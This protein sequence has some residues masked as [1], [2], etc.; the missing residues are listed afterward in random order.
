MKPRAKKLFTFSTAAAL[1]L[2]S[3]Q[4]SALAATDTTYDTSDATSFVFSDSG[5]TVTEGSYTGYKTS[6]TDL[7]INK[8][9]TYV[10]SGDC[11]DG[12]ITVKKGTTGVILVMDG[13]TLTSDDTAPI[14]CNKSTGVTI[15]AADDSTNT[16]TDSAE[17][18]D[19]NY[20]DNEN[21]ENAV[22]K[23]KDGSQVTICGNGT[24]NINANGKNGIKSGSTTDDEGEAWLQIEDATLNITSE[25]G[26]A[27]NAE[28]LLTIASGTITADADDDGIHCDYTLNIGSTGSEGPAINIKNCYEGLEAATL[29]IYSGDIDIHAEDDCLNGANSDLTDYD[30]SITIAGGDLDMDTT[31]GD[32]IDSNGTLT[33]TGGNTEVWTA[34]TSDNQPLD[35]DDTISIT[36]GTVLAAGGSAGMGMQLSAEQPYVIYGGSQSS[37]SISSGSQVDIKDSSN[38][39]IE[40]TTAAC[41]AS[42][43]FFSSD[44][45]T[46][47]DTYQL[48][49]NDSSLASATAQSGDSD[50]STQPGGQPGDASGNQP[51]TPPSGQPGDASGNQPGTPPSGQPGDTSGNQ[52][53]NPPGGQ[54][55][56]ASGNQPGNP[57]SGQPGDSSDNDP[58]GNGS[59]DSSG[60]DTTQADGLSNEAAADGNWYYYE[61]GQIATDVTTVAHNVN[62]WWYV[63]NGKVDFSYTGI[64]Q[65]SYGWWRIENGKVNFNCNS[66]E[67]NEYGWWYIKNGKVDFSYTGIAHNSNGWWRIENGKVNFNCNSVEQNEYGWWYLRNGKVDFSYTGIAYNSNGWWRIE[68]GKVNFNCNSVEQ[69]EYGWWYLQNGKV[70]FSY[71][72]VAGNSNG[73]WYIRNGKVDFSYSGTVSYL[74]KTRTVTNGKVNV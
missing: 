38:N 44:E 68:N 3:L 49:A 66:V 74:G 37:I 1:I 23:C 52:P 19:D 67:Q 24:I 55:S 34:N 64:A 12:S 6:G 61:N 26:D 47:G 41:N 29:N 9:G 42:F 32:G 39:T 50:T 35:A 60:S 22:I 28:Q 43:V 7:T 40:S 17:N 48:Y 46:E 53:G 16:L 57:P 70:D 14:A 10:V 18:N 69:N 65:N 63:K 13:L 58:S 73:Y 33:I 36:G 11:S 45:L 5:I 59:S 54:P 72:G 4:I 20:P 30:F 2:S 15:V 56:D 51:G 62:G 8:A 21:A 31:D 25:A 71:N 27:I